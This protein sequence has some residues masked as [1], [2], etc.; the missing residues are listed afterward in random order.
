MPRA[1]KSPGVQGQRHNPLAEEYLPSDPYK[2][3]VKRTK[4]SKTDE[5]DEQGYVDSKSSRKILE[6][7][8]ELEEEDERENQKGAPKGANPAFDFESRLGEEDLDE[9]VSG[10][11]DDDEEAWGEEEEEVEEVEMLGTSSFPQTTTLFNGQGKRQHHQGRVQI[12]RRLSSRRLLRMKVVLV[13]AMKGHERLW[14]VV[15]PKT[16]SSC[17]RRSLRV[18][19]C[20]DLE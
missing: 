11:F 1:P 13:R 10:Q 8:R 14:A 18:C 9:H 4:R 2:N 16:P 20:S 6:I 19:R 15:R 17:L 7:G 12:W 3:K 5:Q